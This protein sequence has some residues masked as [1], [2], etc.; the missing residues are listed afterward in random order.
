MFELRDEQLVIQ[1]PAFEIF[2]PGPGLLPEQYSAYAEKPISFEC[3]SRVLFQIRCGARLCPAQ[4]D[5][6]QHLV[7]FMRFQ[8][9]PN[10]GPS[11]L[12]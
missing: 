3:S 11:K 1:V 4:R 9:D 12:G 10:F 2:V 5:Q 6:P 8:A 7:T